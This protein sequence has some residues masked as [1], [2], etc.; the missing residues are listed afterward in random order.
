MEDPE[1]NPLSEKRTN[2]TPN[3]YMAPGRNR[4]QATLVGGERSYLCAVLARLIN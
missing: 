1:K 4:S 3:T 2:I